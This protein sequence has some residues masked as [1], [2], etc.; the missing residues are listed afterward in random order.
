MES[1][2]AILERV[3]TTQDL[4]PS[5]N[6]AALTTEVDFYPV[7]DA[8][9]AQGYFIAEH[10]I[11]TTLCQALRTEA[12][13]LY[14]QE[15]M[16]PAGIG[17]GQD[18]IQAPNIRS[19]LTYWLKN[20]TPTQK[21]YLDLMQQLQNTINRELF[22]GLFEYESH[23]ACFPPQSFYA[24]HLDAFRG[25]SNRVVTSILYLNENWQAHQ[26]GAMCLYNPQDQHQQI[27]QVLPES[28]TFVCFLSEMMPHEVS[29]TYR[30]RLSITG[31]FRKNAS[32]G[33][34]D[35]AF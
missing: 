2:A 14:Q 22:L 12:Q 7:I 9:V 30:E 17:R 13:Q 24:T 25:R 1:S 35:P 4:A 18:Y 19:D 5:V 26:G 28:G 27:A 32:L 34:S 31:W 8:L 15:T 3:A 20:T 11:P 6:Q 29:I 16:Q 10:F 21:A 23:Y 33:I